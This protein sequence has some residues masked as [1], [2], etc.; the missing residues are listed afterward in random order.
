MTTV[1]HLLSVTLKSSLAVVCRRSDGAL[2]WAWGSLA[3]TFVL[4]A[5]SG[6]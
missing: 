2:L 4:A 3:I 1:P 6:A 5:C